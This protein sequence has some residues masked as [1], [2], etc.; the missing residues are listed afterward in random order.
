MAPPELPI[1]PELPAPLV[2]WDEPEVEL[3]PMPFPPDIELPLGDPV[4]LPDRDDCWLVCEPDWLEPDSDEPDDEPDR[5][6]PDCEFDLSDFWLEDDAFDDWL[7]EPA[8]EDWLDWLPLFKFES[9]L[10]LLPVPSFG[11]CVSMIRFLF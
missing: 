5:D 11:F 10:S 8:V 7:D 3:V 6:E 9:E 1:E 4:E 2:L